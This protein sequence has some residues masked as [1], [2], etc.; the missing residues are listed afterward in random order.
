VIIKLQ[1]A[2]VE[3]EHICYVKP[4]TKN[5]IPSQHKQRAANTGTLPSFYKDV[6]GGGILG[7]KLCT[8]QIL[9]LC[10]QGLA[11]GCGLREHGGSISLVDH[12]IYALH[13][14]ITKC[15]PGDVYDTLIQNLCSKS[16]PLMERNITNLRFPE[17][18]K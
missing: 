16:Y 8:V 6:P 1:P 11:Q 12:V 13:Y 7:Q 14:V 15:N 18:Y 2:Q 17:H 4:S 10:F 5:S 9:S 3:L